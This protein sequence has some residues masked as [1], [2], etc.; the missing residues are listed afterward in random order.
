MKNTFKILGLAATL[1]V[2]STTLLPATAAAS[3]DCH[4][5]FKAKG[6]SIIYKTLTGYGKVTC[7]DGQTM[8]VKISSKGGGLVAGKSSIDDGKGAFSG[9]NTITDVLGSYAAASG[10]AGAL[11]SADG[12]VVTKGE[13]SLALSGTGRGWDLGVAFSDFTISETHMKH[14]MV[15]PASATSTAQ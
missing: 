7:S 6:W 13:I 4:M 11:K 8:H 3:T 5:T 9:V 2:G 1:A 12:T 10:E 14:K 15:A